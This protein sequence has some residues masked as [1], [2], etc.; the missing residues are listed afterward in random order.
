MT[1]QEQQNLQRVLDGF[2]TLFNRK[3]FEAAKNYWSEHYIQHSAL[4]PPGRQGLFDQVAN[5]LVYE[6]AVAMAKGDLVMLHGRFSN[7]G[8][9]RNWV[10]MDLLRVVDGRMVEH[11]D[12]IQNEASEAESLGGHPMFGDAFADA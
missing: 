2:E 3:D 9:P 5:D 4:V 12:V 6:N 7:T 8:H 11:W 10:T 1:E